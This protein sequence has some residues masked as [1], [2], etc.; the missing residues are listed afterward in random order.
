M[1]TYRLPIINSFSI[2]DTRLTTGNVIPEPMNINFGTNNRFR[3]LLIRFL[4]TSTKDGLAGKFKVPKNYVGSA[5]II[6]DWSATVTT[7]NVVWG[8]DYNHAAAGGSMDPSTDTESLTVTSAAP[9]TARLLVEA[10]I[11][12]TSSNLAIDDEV[13]FLFSRVG[14]SGSDTM[15]SNAYLFSLLFEYTDV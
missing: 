6:I 8:F 5:K 9:G 4:D 14:S 11:S 7:G 15:A 13:M 2:P 12:V 3:H 1:A 10:S